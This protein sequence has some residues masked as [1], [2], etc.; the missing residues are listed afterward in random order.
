MGSGEAGGE[1]GREQQNKQ[2]RGRKRGWEAED[3]FRHVALSKGRVFCL[4][5]TGQEHFGET[6][7]V[8]DH[9]TRNTNICSPKVQKRMENGSQTSLKQ[10]QHDVT[11]GCL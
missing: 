3:I 10:V 4:C 8:C 2:R 5:F 6:R 9:W 11:V 7:R 1:A